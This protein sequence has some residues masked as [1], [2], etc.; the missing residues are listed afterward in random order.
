MSETT[1]M[2]KASIEPAQDGYYWRKATTKNGKEI[3]IA[4]RPLG[5]AFDFAV[6]WPVDDVWK[7]SDDNFLNWSGIANYMVGHSSSLFYRYFIQISAKKTFYFQL[8]DGEGDKYVLR[9]FDTTQDHILRYNS[10]DSNIKRVTN[11]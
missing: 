9:V 7:T 4:I 8:T 11:A 1:T 6:D 5:S 2:T 3:E 10:D